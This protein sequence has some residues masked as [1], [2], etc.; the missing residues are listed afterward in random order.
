VQL[1]LL[2]KEK[3]K[4]SVLLQQ[5][6]GGWGDKMW[7]GS[8]S[9]HVD[10]GESPKEGAQHEAIEEIGVKVKIS[11]MQF[12]SVINKK[13]SQ[14]EIYNNFSFYCTKWTG[15]PKINEPEKIYA[16]KWFDITKLPKNII[17]DRKVALKNFITNKF[18]AEVNEN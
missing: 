17:N 13:V 6:K 7:D 5:R 14:D 9:G 1:Y 2:K 18:Y 4:T 12:M 16:L 11:D 8:A 15:V 10:H 3:G